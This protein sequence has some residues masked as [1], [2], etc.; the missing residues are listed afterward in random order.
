[1]AESW[2]EELSG[3]RTR[4]Q[5]TKLTRGEKRRGGKKTSLKEAETCEKKIASEGNA[6][7]L[8]YQFTATLLVA[9]SI[10]LTFNTGLLSPMQCIDSSTGLDKRDLEAYCLSFGVKMLPP[11]MRNNQPEQTRKTPW[12]K[13]TAI[14]LLIQSVLF[15][16]PHW[17]W[18]HLENG[19]ID[20]MMQDMRR[21][22]VVDSEV[23]RE[24]RK[25]A[26]ECLWRGKIN[27]SVYLA[28]LLLCNYLYL[29]NV[30]LQLYLLIVL[31]DNYLLKNP[32]SVV[33]VLGQ[34]MSSRLDPLELTFPKT[35][36]CTVKYFGT[37]GGMNYLNTY[38]NVGVNYF[39]EVCVISMWYWFLFLLVSTSMSCVARTVQVIFP[40]FIRS[41]LQLSLKGVPARTWDLVF[42]KLSISDLFVL[43]TMVDDMYQSNGEEFVKELCNQMTSKYL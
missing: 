19:W 36:S 33:Y 24:R 3:L 41:Y 35:V 10:Y 16:T 22:D 23:V 31:F 7:K 38:C 17:I 13:W 4:F 2:P 27:N 32:L 34:D 12:Y 8:H 37:A 40:H 28:S 29:I 25:L 21:S 11:S 14:M 18:K 6:F 30:A 15:Y 20:S 39:S 43:K 5:T 42:K 9:C 26:A 1:M